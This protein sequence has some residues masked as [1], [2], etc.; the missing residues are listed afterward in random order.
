MQ[1]GGQAAAPL[2]QLGGRENKG[3]CGRDVSFCQSQ[4]RSQLVTLTTNTAAFLAW[5][6]RCKSFSDT[7]AG[8]LGTV[9][10]P[11]GLLP[12]QANGCFHELLLL[13]KTAFDQM[14][15]R[16]E[17]LTAEPEDGTW[18]LPASAPEGVA[19]NPPKG[20]ATPHPSP[21]HFF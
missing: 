15:Y 7:D 19:L 17:S 4:N 8:P 14:F 20:R 3:A 16:W 12:S 5:P 21:N 2:E 11:T 13:G 1:F 9:P 18:S 6:A 10:R